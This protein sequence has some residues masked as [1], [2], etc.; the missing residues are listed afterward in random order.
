MNKLLAVLKNFLSITGFFVLLTILCLIWTTHE[1]KSANRAMAVIKNAVVITDGKILPE[2]EGRLVLVSGKVIAE[3]SE[4]SDPVFE[5]TVES[6]YLE[7]KVEEYIWVKATEKRRGYYK[8]DGDHGGSTV[9]KVVDMQAHWPY[10]D[11]YFYSTAKIGEFILA[12]RHLYLL[13]SSMVQVTGLQQSVADK[14]GMKVLRGIYYYIPYE[15][16]VSEY[17]ERGDIRISFTTIDTAKL[18]DATIL[19]KQEGDKLVRYS[20]GDDYIN[21]AYEGILSLAEVVKLQNSDAIF[22]PIFAGVI[23]VVVGIPTFFL[24]RWKFRRKKG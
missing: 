3:G 4:V 6:P 15:G 18:G 5:I 22:M 10:R 2:N 12:L 20:N 1:I 7:R 8:W 13:K 16:K 14:L 11:R 17:Y 24:V 9:S 23:S 19:A 21:Y